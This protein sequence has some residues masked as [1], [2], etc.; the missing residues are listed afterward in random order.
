MNENYQETRK[1]TEVTESGEWY[2]RAEKRFEKQK[3]E[4]QIKELELQIE[5]YEFAICQLKK[6]IEELSK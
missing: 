5:S 2:P 6:R 4:K 1:I 3:K